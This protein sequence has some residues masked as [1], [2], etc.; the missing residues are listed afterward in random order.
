MKRAQKTVKRRNPYRLVAY[1]PPPKVTFSSRQG[2]AAAARAWLDEKPDVQLV[3]IVEVG[4]GRISTVTRNPKRPARKVGA[5]SFRKTAR[6]NPPQGAKAM[7]EKFHGRPSTK[8]VT[9]QVAR[10]HHEHLAHLG[11]LVEL[12]VILPD[13]QLVKLEP[14]GVNLASSE[15]G[16]QLYFVG[17]DQKLNLTRLG[18]GET[19]PK[20]HIVVGPVQSV[21]YH[22]EKKFDGFKPLTYEHEFG[23]DGGE[24][25]TLCYDV[26]SQLMYLAGGS[27]QNLKPGIVN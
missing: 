15:D 18:L 24:L 3:E 26:R 21:A 19:L 10:H 17:G 5:R 27:Y 8:A 1:P 11:K 4:K 2:A 7:F 23:E 20:D 13:D 9:H 14:K 25:P 16:G 22:T 12:V 6:R